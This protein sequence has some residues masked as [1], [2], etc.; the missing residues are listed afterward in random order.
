MCRQPTTTAVRAEHVKLSTV[1]EAEP[2][3]A[4]GILGVYEWVCVRVG[5]VGGIS[6]VW[7]AE[8]TEPNA[9]SG[10]GETVFFNW[11]GTRSLQQ[12][13]PAL[14]LSLACRGGTFSIFPI[15]HRVRRDRRLCAVVVWGGGSVPTWCL[16]RQSRA[17][18]AST[19]RK[20]RGR[21]VFGTRLAAVRWGGERR[22]SGR[23][24]RQLA[25][26]C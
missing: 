16:R 14:F 3:N 15:A 25:T 1:S 7:A 17:G 22:S 8:R 12:K 23:L 24:G 19:H 2:L 9:T 5:E 10:L 26:S 18:A 6:T 21:T 11:E 20:R 13:L 4:H